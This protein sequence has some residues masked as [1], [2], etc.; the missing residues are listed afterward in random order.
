MRLIFCLLFS[1]CILYANKNF[2]YSFIDISGQQI[3][4]SQK[5]KILDGYDHLNAIA[6]ILKE[7]DVDVAYDRILELESNNT[8]DILKSPIMILRSEIM[9]KKEARRFAIEGAIY[10]ERAINSSQ[11][12]EDDLPR[13]YMT[14]IDLLIKINKVDEAQYFA[15]MLEKSFDDPLVNAYGKIYQ[16]KIITNKKEFEKSTR[17]LYE[18]LTQTKSLDVATVVA[19]E[20]FDVFIL[21]DQKDKA[22]ELI[23]QVVENN[24]QYYVNNSFEA[25][26]KVKK[27]QENG[28][29]EFAAKILEAILE[30]T[31][32]PFLVEEF[33]FRLG[34]AYMDMYTIN[35]NYLSKAKELFE[36]IYNDFRDGKY[37]VEAKMSLDEILMRERRIEPSVLAERYPESF[38]M[39]QKVLLQ[40]L[41]NLA[42]IKD[43]ENI[44]RAKSIYDKI[45]DPIAKRFGYD[46]IQ[47]LFDIITAQMIKDYLAKD[48][49]KE[50]VDVIDYTTPKT[51]QIL[52]EEKSVSRELFK[53]L[54]DYPHEKAYFIAKESFNSSRD[55]EI[56]LYLEQIALNLG[57]FDEAYGMSQKVDMVGNKDILNQEFLYKFLILTQ[58]NDQF[59]LERFFQNTKNN[60]ILINANLEQPVIIDFYY[61]Y[62]FYLLNNGF[63]FDAYD[64][65]QK[66]YN[67]QIEF[68]ARVYSPFVEMELAKYESDKN[69]FTEALV[70]LEEGLSKSRY[71]KPDLKVQLF[72]EKAKNHKS[73]NQEDLMKESVQKCIE[74]EGLVDNLYQ[75]MCKRL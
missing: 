34:V 45:P 7:G 42:D 59:L 52:I 47:E 61:R 24:I 2:T 33:K 40:E 69:N 71:I 20:L 30:Q 51:F 15:D 37:S 49:C 21:N 22:H 54:V 36:D 25:L 32:N 9:L 57:L 23:K 27:L 66:L 68:K 64:I 55:A 44:L 14:L 65:L 60:P 6:T 1:I 19:H 53:C 58:K 35:S 17:M 16:S 38:S 72:Y 31:K 75:Q 50:L 3:S 8:I 41:L 11:I 26:Q 10:L 67:K 73:L 4:H 74:I 70:Y 5:Q 43:Y 46:N 13:A 48:S 39:E 29:A 62:Y 63:S 12:H 28:M 18:I 56:Y